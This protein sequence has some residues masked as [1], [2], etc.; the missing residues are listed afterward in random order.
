[1]D[2]KDEESLL[3]L[4]EMRADLAHCFS[5]A[6][7]GINAYDLNLSLT[8]QSTMARL[9]DSFVKVLDKIED[10]ENQSSDN[11]QRVVK[12]RANRTP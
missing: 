6:K 2:L 1:M 11:G 10:L 4:K 3:T 12:R 9:A 8:S 7:E 5:L